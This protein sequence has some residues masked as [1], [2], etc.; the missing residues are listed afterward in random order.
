MAGQ[1][2]SEKRPRRD[3]GPPKDI[4]PDECWF[5]LSNPKVTK[6]LIASIGSE[7]YLT[8]PKGQLL[9]TA[10]STKALVPGGGHCLIIPIAHY[11][12]M[13]AIPDDL[14]APMQAEIQAYMR[15]L[16]SCY[17]S[18]GAKLLAFE[19]SRAGLGG[20]KAGHAHIQVCPIPASLAK[21]A[22]QMFVD[23]GQKAGYDFVSDTEQPVDGILKAGNY[24][25]LDLP[26]GEKLVHEIKP[27]ERFSLQFG[28]ATTA[29]LLNDAT[30]SDWKVCAK[31]DDEEAKDCQAFKAA[32]AK[33]DPSG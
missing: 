14:A 17:E 3:D 11:P 4:A 19:V 16:K 2:S 5:C 15:A 20:G 21:N 9:D 31:P 24:L 23:E 27:G 22:K 29:I 13:S 6:H 25:K 30:R 26:D 28:R 12:T 10:D 18:Y 8:L 1:N 33:C 7:A 32:F